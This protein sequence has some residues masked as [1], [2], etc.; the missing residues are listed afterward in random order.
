MLRVREK[1]SRL[2]SPNHHPAYI[3]TATTT[4]AADVVPRHHRDLVRLKFSLLSHLIFALGHNC[5]S[6]NTNSLDVG[7][8]P[9]H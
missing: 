4:R 1:N 8:R 5:S 2:D 6:A 3:L 7:G 9:T